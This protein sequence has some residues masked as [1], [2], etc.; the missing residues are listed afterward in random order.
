MNKYG[1]LNESGEVGMVFAT[2][3][4]AIAT[5]GLHDTDWVKLI[6]NRWWIDS[7]WSDA[8]GN[9]ITEAREI[10]ELNRLIAR[11]GIAKKKIAEIAGV[12]PATVTRWISGETPVPPLVL[13]RLQEIDRVVN[14]K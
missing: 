10:Q 14:K 4:E 12:V 6:P 8:D 2:E 9:F 13:E 11:T 3:A 1:V 7:D 5:A